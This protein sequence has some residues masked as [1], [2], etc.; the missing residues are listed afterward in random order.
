M[1]HHHVVA[2]L[3][4]ALLA[5][6][7]T[8]TLWSATVGLP[9]QGSLPLT[10]EERAI[11]SPVLLSNR[12]GSLAAVAPGRFFLPPPNLA[13]EVMFCSAGEQAAHRR[14]CLGLKPR[15]PL[16]FHGTSAC[17]SK[18]GP[19]GPC[20]RLDRENLRDG[21]RGINRG[22]ISRPGKGQC[23][24]GVRLFGGH[25][26]NFANSGSARCER[27]CSCPTDRSENLCRGSRYRRSRIRR[28]SE[29]GRRQ[30]DRFRGLETFAKLV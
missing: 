12:M 9:P 5:G 2:R 27:A 19:S 6:H 4:A 29:S 15:K 20:C 21:C 14:M 24:I 25:E 1:L 16:V 17:V 23:L 11:W 3:P 8:Q 18:Q 7:P 26:T 10:V 30:R 28:P 22:T 13:R